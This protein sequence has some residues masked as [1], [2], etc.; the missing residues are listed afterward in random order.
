V[1]QHWPAIERLAAAL[2]ERGTLT[3]A[4]LGALMS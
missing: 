3:G 4:D 2:Q 1:R